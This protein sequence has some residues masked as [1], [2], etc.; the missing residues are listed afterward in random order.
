M[1]INSKRSLLDGI[2]N[3]IKKGHIFFYIDE[4]N[5]S[6]VRDKMYMTYDNYIKHPLQA[7]ELKLNMM[8]AKKPHRMNS[9]NRSHNHALNQKTSYFNKI[10]SQDKKNTKKTVKVLYNYLYS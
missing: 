9:L 4:M 10:E 7:I 6:A 2:E 8:A 1:L 5:I 3:F